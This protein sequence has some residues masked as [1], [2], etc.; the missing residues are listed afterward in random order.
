MMEALPLKK[1]KDSE[2][3]YDMIRHGEKLMVYS[4]H[5]NKVF[6]QVT[7]ILNNLEVDD[8]KDTLSCDYLFIDRERGCE[9]TFTFTRRIDKLHR[10]NSLTYLE[11]GMKRWERNP[12]YLIDKTK[13]SLSDSNNWFDLF[14]KRIFGV[15]N[16]ILRNFL[17]SINKYGELFDYN[18]VKEMKR[19][20]GLSEN[21]SKF[22]DDMIF[23][24]VP[25][26][27]RWIHLLTN[28]HLNGTQFFSDFITLQCQNNIDGSFDKYDEVRLVKK[29]TNVDITYCFVNEKYRGRDTSLKM[30]LIKGNSLLSSLIKNI[31]YRKLLDMSFYHKL[32]KF[33]IEDNKN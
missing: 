18:A 1:M 25:Y 9:G 7:Y 21:K 29:E 12:V 15:C 14:R 6:R 3:V 33:I 4:L 2:S 27:K 10:L 24:R 22:F 30:Y 31:D 13:L 23:V 19:N 32:D 17:F 8:I 5:Y 16:F 20:Y 11:D 26:H 28:I